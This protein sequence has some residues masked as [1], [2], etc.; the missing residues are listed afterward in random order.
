[1]NKYFWIG[2]TAILL[3]AAT[4]ASKADNITS[5][6]NTSPPFANGSQ[7]STVAVEAAASGEAS[8]FDD[9]NNQI[10][11]SDTTSNTNCSASWTFSNLAIPSSQTITGATLTLGIWDI[12]SA[13][14][15]T[16]VASYEITGG[17]DLTA[18]LNAAAEAVNGHGSLNKEYDVFT[19]TLT[20]F[21]GLAAGNTT[22]SLT[23]QGPG[24]GV[25]G[26][27]PSN[28]AGLVF[29][30]LDIQTAPAGT[31]VP[32]PSALQLLLTG[33]GLITLLGTSRKLGWSKLNAVVTREM[34]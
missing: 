33:I 34:R 26:T 20:S 13:A 30:T 17:D 4:S 27:T 10:C 31:D 15:G 12:D 18:S 1:M 5:I 32:E 7:P 19:L 11:G 22:V 14:P 16:Q 21:G 25:L 23:L 28:G 3:F 9:A 6:G 24:L 2:A 29:S 8:P